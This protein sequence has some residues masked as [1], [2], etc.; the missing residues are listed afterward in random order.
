MNLPNI[1]FYN[2]VGFENWDW[3]NPGEFGIGGSETFQIEMSRRFARRGYNVVCYSL[4]DSNVPNDVGDGY[5][6]QWKHYDEADKTQPGWWIIQRS[7]KSVDEFEPTKNNQKLWMVCQD[8]SYGE[9]SGG[10]WLEDRVEKLDVI[11]ALCPAQRS[12]FLTEYPKVMKDNKIFV[13]GNGISNNKIPSLKKTLEA[14]RDYKKL[15]Y[16]SSPDRGLE[17][18][19]QIFR[20]AREYD[21]E[22]T[23]D[24]YYGFDN[25]DKIIA[26]DPNSVFVAP[27]NRIMAEL[28]QP[29]VT[30]HGRT[31][32]HK[33]WDV[34]THAGIW[35]YPTTFTE[36][37][38]ITCMEAQ[39]LGAIP[40]TTPIWALDANVKH[41]CLV[42]GDA[43]GDTQARLRYVHAILSIANNPE[44][45]DRIRSEMCIWARAA[46][47]WERVVDMY[48]ARYNLIY[49][50]AMASQYSF[51]NRWAVGPVLNVGC[52]ADQNKL[53]GTHPDSVNVDITPIDPITNQENDIDEIADARDLPE[54]FHG[55][56]KTVVL[57]EILE[58]FNDEDAIKALTCARKCLQADGRVLIT[59]PEDYRSPEEQHSVITKYADDVSAFHERPI[60]LDMIKGWLAKAGLEIVFK[61][62]IEYYSFT[63]HGILAKAI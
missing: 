44:L 18:L 41:G 51:Q 5:N 31:Q 45:Q 60:T 12:Y 42:H 29:G 1:Y 57:G 9:Y 55:K 20:R 56:F 48:E 14:K 2:P 17:T 25:I 43:N 7:P 63:G 4:N 22:L 61:D 37:S 23:L 38:C 11:V 40:I 30:F 50:R 54:K 39:A 21:P 35:C 24:I 59:C 46:F 19:L 32:Q 36:T 62:Y 8:V 33:L 58:H 49:S 26:G 10:A 6:I 16:A 15:I 3:R 13:V 28:D 34:W 27:K 53:R 52:N 47:S